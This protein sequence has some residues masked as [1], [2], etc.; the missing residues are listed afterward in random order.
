V[1]LP[2]DFEL[3]LARLSKDLG[4]LQRT[5]QELL[6]A[7]ERPHAARRTR[8]S[9]ES[10]QYAVLEAAL[11]IS[12]ATVSTLHEQADVVQDRAVRASS[13]SGALRT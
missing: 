3:R 6:A 12:E 13:R 8:N 5:V 7:F 4:Q 1:K 9:V 10:V 11:R 2:P